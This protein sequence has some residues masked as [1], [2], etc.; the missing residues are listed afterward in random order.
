M[1]VFSTFISS[2][3][4][5]E[6]EGGGRRGGGG[7][8][9]GYDDVQRRRRRMMLQCAGYTQHSDTQSKVIL[10]RG[11]TPSILSHF[12]VLMIHSQSFMW[13]RH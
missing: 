7:G 1:H 11:E 12:P 8:E 5:R 9:G 13:N 6:R 2:D 3:Q 10:F 4:E